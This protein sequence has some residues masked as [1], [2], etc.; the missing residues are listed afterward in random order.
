MLDIPSD[1]LFLSQ[2]L[3]V[4][5]KLTVHNGY[6]EQYCKKNKKYYIRFQ[7][8]VYSLLPIRLSLVIKV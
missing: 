7:R 6:S 2:K 4:P 8:V 3:Y 5:I 1:T